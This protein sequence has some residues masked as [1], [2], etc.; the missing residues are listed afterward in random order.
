MRISD[1]SSDVCSSDL[2]LGCSGCVAHTASTSMGGKKRRSVTQGAN[3]YFTR[4]NQ[5]CVGQSNKADG[6]R[7]STES[8]PSERRLGLALAAAIRYPAANVPAP[9]R[10]PTCCVVY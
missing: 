7:T 1:W 4:R 6:S 9:V 3:R 2:V 5:G 10:L 8:A